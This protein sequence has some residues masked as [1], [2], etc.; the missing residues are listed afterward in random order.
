MVLTKLCTQLGVAWQK[1]CFSR[2]SFEAAREALVNWVENAR[3]TNTPLNRAEF[4]RMGLTPIDSG[5]HATAFS[6]ACGRFVLKVNFAYDEAYRRFVDLAMTRQDNPY[7]PR[8]YYSHHSPEFQVVLMEPLHPLRSDLPQWQEAE[9]LQQ[10]VCFG[11]MP[12]NPKGD[13]NFTKLVWD[14]WSLFDQDGLAEDL[15]GRNLMVR[16]QAGTLQLVVTDPVCNKGNS[17]W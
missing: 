3:Q 5:K 2:L 9:Y 16:K 13:A 7:Y 10:Q 14:M 15:S 11:L 6:S 8:I 4:L 1:H 12:R 17:S